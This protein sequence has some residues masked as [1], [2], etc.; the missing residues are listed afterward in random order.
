[1][2]EYHLRDLVYNAF[3]VHV[4]SYCEQEQFERVRPTVERILDQ[5]WR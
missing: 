5:I 3:I 1:M 2:L 4:Q